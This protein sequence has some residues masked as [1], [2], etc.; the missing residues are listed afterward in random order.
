MTEYTLHYFGVN[1]RATLPRAILSHFK[2]SWTDHKVDYFT[3]WQGMKKSGL[4][5]F[6][7]LPVLEH[8]DK[9]MAQSNAITYY[10]ARKFN[11][12]GTNDEENFQIDSLLC[13]FEDIMQY[14]VNWK[15]CHHEETA[16]KLK[17]LALEKY[18]FFIKKFEE[19]YVKSGKGKYFMGDRFTLC[20]VIIGAGLPGFCDSFEDKIVPQVSQILSEF[21]ERLMKEEFADFFANH[22]VP[23]NKFTLT[24]FAGN[25][26]AVIARAILSYGKANWTDKKM[27]YEEWPAIKKSGLCEFE[28]VPV[29]EHNN[30][31]LAQSLAIDFYLARHFNLMGKNSD[32]NYQIE[33]LMCCFEDIF[34]PIWKFMFCKDEKEKEEL[35]KAAREKYEFFIKKLEDRYVKNGKGK[36]FMGDR[37]TLADIFIGAALP[38]ACDCFGEKIVPKV[39]PVLNE[40]CGRIMEGELKEFHEK[41]FVKSQ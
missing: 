28:Q 19:R 41:Y 22:F 11:I 1:G 36:Y 7:Q 15:H 10:L 21:V 2:A 23:A 16:K 27:K 9:K 35:K 30:K 17:E 31:K 18:K 3:E 33:S 38:S 20:D 8:G 37:F 6:E 26:R 12:L 32:E 25:G 40:L 5:E 29:L 4:C 14:I 13:C 39:S 34:A 24:Y